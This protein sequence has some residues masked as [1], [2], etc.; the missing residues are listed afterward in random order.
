[1]HATVFRSVISRLP[2]HAALCVLTTGAARAGAPETGAEPAPAA[3]SW[4]DAFK[5]DLD[6]RARA[7]WTDNVRDFNSDRHAADDDGWLITRSRLGLGWQAADWLKFYA[8]GQDSRELFSGRK[9]DTLNGANGDNEF[10][11]RQAYI[12]FGS[13]EHSPLVFTLGRQSLD[14]GSRRV[15]ADSSW[16][17]YGRTFDA[18]RLSWKATKDWQIDGFAGHVVTI[19]PGEFDDSD[20]ASDLAGIYASGKLPGKQTLDFYAVYLG[21]EDSRIAPV[22]GN[23]WTFGSRLFKKPGKDSPWDYELEGVVQAGDVIS[24]GRELDLLAF[25]AQG[26]LGYT[27]NAPWSPRVSVNYSF[28]SGDDDRTDGDMDR[29]QPVYPSTHAMN[30]L[31][32]SLG[33]AN[34]HDPY[35]ELKVTPVED[36]TVGFQAHAFFRAETGDFVYRANGYSPLRTPAGSGGSSYIGT[37]LDLYVQTNLTKDLEL[38]AGTGVLFAGDYLASTGPSDNA[39][40]AYLQLTYK[41]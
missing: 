23:F 3:D 15:V 27:F 2:L 17:N 7:E 30:G 25:G 37:E 29:L 34:L 33:W 19:K 11:L 18:A 41:Y 32:D 26:T 5:F 35:L 6:L 10:D 38:L 21:S 31:L 40:T 9:H 36:W 14:Y 39:T 24:G 16:S 20:G 4:R 1:M 13:P 12:A 22:R 8:Q 28:A